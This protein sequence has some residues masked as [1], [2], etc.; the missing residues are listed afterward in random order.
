MY[1]LKKAIQPMILPPG[2]FILLLLIGGGWMVYRKR[3]ACAV[4]L[5]S[6]TAIMYVLALP[7]I[8]D[9]FI[10]GLERFHAIPENPRGDV[11]VMMGGAVYGAV[12]DMTGRG[13][14]TPGSC[15]RI[16]TTARLYRKLK[17]P[18]ILTGGRVLDHHPL[19]GPIYKRML[20]DLG[21][22]EDDIYLE[23]RSRDT[24]E[25]AIFTSQ[26]CRVS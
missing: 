17:L 7:P 16:L 2:F 1:I 4:A 15:E 14:P 18:I 20:V 3:F 25:N 8:A 9:R 22:P 21:I 26:L 24:F 11:I 6:I 12:P 5:L 19:M 10:Q 13:A 23:S